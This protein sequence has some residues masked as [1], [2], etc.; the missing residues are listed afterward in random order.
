MSDRQ[1]ILDTETTGMRV[2]DGHR[3]I[4]IGCV[5]MINRKLTGNHFHYYINPQ[6]EVDPGAY[7]VHGIS[8]EFLA[9]KPFFLQIA[10][11]LID[12]IDGAELIIH[13]A[14]FDIAFLNH[15]L[16][17]TKQSWKNVGEYCRIV[18]TLPMA[19]KM[20][21]GQ[22]N[23]LDALCKRYSIDNSKRELHGALMDA[24]LLAQVYLAMTGGQGNFFDAL[25][26]KTSQT[27]NALQAETT[28]H[29]N[30]KITVLQASTEETEEHDKYLQLLQ[31][32]GKCVWFDD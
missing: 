32:Q 26:E 31:K 23:S 8:D 7:A 12:F 3:I 29:V 30:H 19:R 24:N 16:G 20:H 21:V 1:V 9:D 2:E 15:E 14:P 11:D 13:N 22:R 28:A 4:E 6:R 25:T 17:L 5:E 18:D 27:G 10:K